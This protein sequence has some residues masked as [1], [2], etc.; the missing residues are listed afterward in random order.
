MK[1]IKRILLGLILVMVLAMTAC[2]GAHTSEEY[3]MKYAVEET[4]AAMDYPAMEEAAY[5]SGYA[6]N[7]AAGVDGQV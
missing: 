3:E 5:D 1:N 2:G 7:L 6:M 4:A